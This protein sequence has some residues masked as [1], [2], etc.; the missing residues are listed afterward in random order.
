ML[1]R[2]LAQFVRVF[3]TERVA[4]SDNL[5]IS[6]LHGT[7]VRYA[8][9]Q[10]GLDSSIEELRSIAAGRDDLIAQAAGI[11]AGSWLA[12]PQVH[13]GHELVAVGMLIMAANG[14]DYDLLARWVQIGFERG[15]AA[16]QPVHGPP[17][18]NGIG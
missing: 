18:G 12:W 8:V 13:V 6:A 15:L 11:T 5:L 9:E 7:A 14:L 1:S 16:K 4:T 10:R 3:D 17:I 2:P